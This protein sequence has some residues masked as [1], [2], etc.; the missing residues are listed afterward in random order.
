VTF[1]DFETTMESQ[2]SLLGDTDL[3]I[4]TGSREEVESGDTTSVLGALRRLLERDMA[5]QLRQRVFFGVL[6]Y[7]DDPRELFEIPEVR[8]WIAAVDAEWPY[9]F[10]FLYPGPR[11]TLPLIAFS[12]CP[13][14]AVPGG[15]RS[16]RPISRRS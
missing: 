13:F 8:A 1:V 10:F 3:L 12:V 4:I 11:T 14:E 15:N 7:D 16:R 5:L 9:W 2:P 6:G